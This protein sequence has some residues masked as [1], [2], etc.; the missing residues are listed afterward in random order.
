MQ[1]A[2]IED[3]VLLSNVRVGQKA[4]IRRAILDKN[5]V[6]LD[7]GQVGVDA[8]ADRARG[9]TVS[10]GGITVVGKGVTIGPPS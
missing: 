5:V 10:E 4:T 8:E 3:S 2:V 1:K 7:G 6:V 9:F